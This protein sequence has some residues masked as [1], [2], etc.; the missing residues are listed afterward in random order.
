MISKRAYNTT[1][2][3]DYRYDFAGNQKSTHF[4]SVRARP[5]PARP[6]PSFSSPSE[7]SRGSRTLQRLGEDFRDLHRVERGAFADVVG[8]DPEIEA[9]RMRNVLADAPDEDGVLSGR[10]R[11]RRRVAAGFALVDDDD[12]RRRFEQRARFGGRDFFL[13]LDVHRFG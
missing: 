8:D 13:R 10:V 3:M 6:P 11:H 1:V 7:D 9:A 4:G 2:T 5:R 12:T